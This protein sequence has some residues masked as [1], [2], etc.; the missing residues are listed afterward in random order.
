SSRGAYSAHPAHSTSLP[1]PDMRIMF[2]IHMVRTG[3]DSRQGLRDA[4]DDT[5]LRREGD[6]QVPAGPRARRTRETLLNAAT[7]LFAE[8][9]YFDTSV[10]QI[11]E[12]AGVGLGTYYQYFRDRTDIMTTLVRTTVINVL[13]VDRRWDPSRGRSGVRS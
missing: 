6:R 4:R 7:E 1:G 8:Q 5:A 11:A 12:R 3:N 2:W 13:K 10:G 9:G